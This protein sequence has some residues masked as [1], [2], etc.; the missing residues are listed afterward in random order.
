M[1]CPCKSRHAF[2]DKSEDEDDASDSEGH[3]DDEEDEEGELLY[4][5]VATTKKKKDEDDLLRCWRSRW[6]T[7]DGGASQ[8]HGHDADQ[9]D[10][11]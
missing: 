11:V 1:W 10:C 3:R 9:N 4:Q 2:T 7:A 8:W 5:L 6:V